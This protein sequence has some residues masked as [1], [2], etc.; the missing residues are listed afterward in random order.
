MHFNRQKWNHI[1]RSDK[2]IGRRKRENMTTETTINDKVTSRVIPG[3]K[4]EYRIVAL[5]AWAWFWLD[6]FMIQN[7]MSYEGILE[8]FQCET[9][10]SQ[11]LQYIAELHQEHCMRGVHK[12]S[13]DN[14]FLESDIKVGKKKNGT[15]AYNMPKIFKLFGFIPCVTT[16]NSVWTR[17]NYDEYN[18][19]N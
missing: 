14:T 10:I 2:H 7:R 1:Y 9:D 3:L 8:T 5:P 19:I 13:N 4:S 6:D 17:K 15:K 16:L 11:S 12:L 18:Q